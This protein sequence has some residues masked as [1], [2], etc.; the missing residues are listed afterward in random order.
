MIVYDDEALICLDG[1]LDGGEAPAFHRTIDD[2]RR[3]GIRRVV[4]D[5][6]HV[7]TIDDA[8]SA[9]L[10]AA[11]SSLRG[12]LVLLMPDGSVATVDDAASLRA[13]LDADTA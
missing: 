6:S 9:V 3:L 12:G 4:V 5:L 7:V 11:A 1:P 2:A 8:G 10:A 13:L